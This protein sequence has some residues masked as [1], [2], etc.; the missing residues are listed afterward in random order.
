MFVDMELEKYLNSKDFAAACG[1][2]PAA[3]T[4]A[5]KKGHLVRDGKNRL[6]TR[7]PR[8]KAYLDL[9]TKTPHQIALSKFSGPPK[10]HT[11]MTPEE[12]AYDVAY[13]KEQGLMEKGD[14][15]TKIDVEIARIRAQTVKINMDIAEKAGRFILKDLVSKVF[16]ELAST[17]ANLVHPMGQRLSSD[18]CDVLGITDPNKILKVQAMIDTENERYISEVKRITAKGI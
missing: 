9:K 17:T 13:E 3:I 15:A 11:N 1:V 6:N 10:L 12:V 4:K 8:N 7:L 18:I 2:S 14:K 16:G 5:V